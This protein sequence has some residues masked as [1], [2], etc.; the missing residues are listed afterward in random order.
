MSDLAPLSLQLPLLV[1]WLIVKCRCFLF[2]TLQAT[3]TT[4]AAHT[5]TTWY[6]ADYISDQ[7]EVSWKVSLEIAWLSK[8][9]ATVLTCQAKWLKNISDIMSWCFQQIWYHNIFHDQS[10]FTLQLYRCYSCSSLHMGLSDAEME[11]A[12]LHDWSTS[13]V[14][15]S[16]WHTAVMR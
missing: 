3:L 8:L 14:G 16:Y 5:R 7:V 2:I 4:C 15:W 13:A 6:A 10:T 9:A 1:F 11:Q 12:P